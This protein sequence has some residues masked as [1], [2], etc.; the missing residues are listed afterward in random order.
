[1]NVLYDPGDPARARVA[2]TAGAELGLWAMYV[3]VGVFFVLFALRGLVAQ[4]T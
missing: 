2:E 1:M 4:L 3:A